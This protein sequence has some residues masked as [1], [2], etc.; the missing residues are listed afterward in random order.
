MCIFKIKKYVPLIIGLAALLPSA[1]A[2]RDLPTEQVSIIKDFDARLLESNKINVPPSLPPLDTVSKRFDYLVP[3]RP[4]AVAYEVPTLRP[5]SMRTVRPEKP[6]NGFAKLGGGAPN[7]YWGEAGYAFQ[8]KD[9]FDGKAWFRHHQANNK[10]LENQRFANN[11]AYLNF[12][13]YLENNLAVEG[14]GRYSADRVFFYGY[15]HDSLQFN[16]D[17]VRQEFNLFEIRGRL[18]NSQ[19][20]DLD[21]NFSVAPLFYRLSD[22][23]SNG[24][25]GFA[26]D[27]Q[28]T[29]WFA[30]RH[31][32]RVGIRPDLTSY[33]DTAKQKLNNIYL[34]PSLSLHF[35]F[36]RLKLGGNFVN[37]RDEFSI[38]PDAEVLVRLWGDGV[39][40]FGGATGDLRKNTYR[41]M[42]EY[43]P[44]LQMRASR[45]RNT[46]WR[47][48][49][50]GVKGNFGWFNYEG[51]LSYGRAANLALFQTQYDSI[52]RPGITRFRTVY[53]SV[54]IFGVSGAVNVQVS[55]AIVVSGTASYRAFELSNENEA[56]GLPNLEVNARVLFQPYEGK[57]TLKGELY[58]AD[59]IPFRNQAD[60]PSFTDL[61][62]DLNAGA[63]MQ[64]TDYVGIFLDLNNIL[65]N[66]RERWLSYPMLGINILGGATVR[67]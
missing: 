15:D 38:F 35:S 14:T 40:V 47:E 57:I 11:D 18:Y 43:N 53:D 16:A 34:Q 63:T 8:V 17:Q 22:Y 60:Q 27:L 29:K 20:N 45:L 49:Y 54:Q 10:K 13:Y 26:L 58:L 7:Q 59:D 24:E 65:N 3:P 2:Q 12:N 32:L 36:L 6:F 41:S 23:Y 28:L 5:L 31:A 21:L 61:L 48:F 67:F 19:R 39:Q 52:G 56:W 51:R 55:D 50:G 37:N 33:N 42:S 62:F 64:I 25:T 44:F 9:K 30:Q 66:R 46:V 1:Q 4:Q